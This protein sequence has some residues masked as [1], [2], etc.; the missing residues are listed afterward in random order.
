MANGVGRPTVLRQKSTN[1]PSTYGGSKQS[2]EEET[3]GLC[4]E[5]TYASTVGTA[6]ATKHSKRAQSL[7]EKAAHGGDLI[8][9]S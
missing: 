5:E 8:T 2:E 7:P 4:G 3:G 1:R 9:R 6:A